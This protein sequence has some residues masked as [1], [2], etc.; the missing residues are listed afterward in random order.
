MNGRL[1]W[2]LALSNIRHRVSASA[3]LFALLALTVLLLHIGM[4][5]SLNLGSF[6]RSKLE[7][8]QAPDLLA[9]FKEESGGAMLR[10][11]VSGFPGTVYWEEEEALRIPEAKIAYGGSDM[12]V[13][14]VFLNADT[15]RTLSPF[16]SAD[17]RR[18][19]DGSLIY[20]PYMFRFSGGYEAGDPITL[21]AGDTVHTLEVGGFYEE[22]LLSTFTNGSVKAML[23]SRAYE[24]MREKLG[25]EGVLR[26]LSTET[27]NAEQAAELTRLL[28]N[29]M[30]DQA[31]GMGYFL[32]EA[33]SGVAGNR[34]IVNM[35][36]VI[37]V[38]FS[39]LLALIALIVVRFQ[40][41]EQLEDYMV[42]LGVLKANGYT[43]R[44][45]SRALLLQFLAI[46]CA[47][48]L[49]GLAIAGMLM[50]AAGNMISSSLGLLWPSAYDWRSAGLSLL[51]IAALT[52]GVVA[53]SGRRL[54]VITPLQALRQGLPGHSFN[55]NP[56]PLAS[57][58]LSLQL[59]L[60]LKRLF[61]QTKQNAMLVFIVT[62]LMFASAFCGMLH[63]NM[64]EGRTVILDLVGLERASLSLER[65][66][67]TLNETQMTEL[68][69]MDGV[70]KLL[71]LDY[72]SAT[73]GGQ[74]I[75]LTVTPDFGQLVNQTVYRGRNPE[76]DN[77]IALSG[78]VGKRIGKT[79]GDEVTVTV[80]DTS[81]TY[82]ITGLSQ[83]ISQLGMV[84]SMT[85]EGAYRLVPGFD[86]RTA[87][88]YLAEGADEDHFNA[89]I[90]ATYPG[91]WNKVNLKEWTESTFGTF[92]FSVRT[93]TWAITLI[94]MAVVSL[95]L[96]LVI[97]ML[98]AKRK[99]E[100]G[101][102]QVMGFTSFQIRT[103]ITFSLL[104]VI[105]AGV[106]LGS[107]MGY[108]FS[109]E[110]LALLLSGVGIYNVNAAAD[111]GQVLLSAGGIIGLSY[112]VSMLVSRRIRRITPYGLISE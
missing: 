50:P 101:I 32:L 52:A 45:L 48:S 30:A 73:V 108:F 41:L 18:D 84:A 93:M 89:I 21:R 94:T 36:A 56:L 86:F 33:E 28:G 110:L 106:L 62:G 92:A 81:Q 3:A 95:I 1:A 107:A 60:G 67:G 69:A 24:E 105:A 54:S 34:I 19:E 85:D 68:G 65:K 87:Y 14:F 49:P 109:D 70:E 27:E 96:Y 15:P 7:E 55:G 25:E 80:G 78:I 40:I 53:L 35:L 20:L 59:A 4:S 57:S 75:S 76:Y 22:A 82:L 38:V 64:G 71:P 72:L 90:E 46:A 16:H 100:F 111:P 61:R 8:L 17:A 63:Y 11:T 23:N 10:N 88:L 37:L 104:P 66:Q 26:F 5:V 39:L 51:A 31:P 9:Y 102:L 83:Q 103:Q 6:Q 12:P 43:S 91:E 2:K 112:A 42:N 79:I 44:Q 98:I 13:A 74:L 47:A 97:K 77:E 29:Q 99:K 58:R